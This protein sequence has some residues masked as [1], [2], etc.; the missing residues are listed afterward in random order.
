MQGSDVTHDFNVLALPLEL[1]VHTVC[2]QALP[3]RLLA[4]MVM[5]FGPN[6]GGIVEP[7]QLSLTPLKYSLC[8][9]TV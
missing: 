4:H 9:V 1:M 8:I 6:Q 5:C 3:L 7:Y 2:V